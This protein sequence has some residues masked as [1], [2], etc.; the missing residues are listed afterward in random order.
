MK[1]LTTILALALSGCAFDT[2]IGYAGA[3]VGLHLESAKQKAELPV[4][5]G[6]AK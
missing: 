2:T 6:F 3:T 1:T 5:K 4:V